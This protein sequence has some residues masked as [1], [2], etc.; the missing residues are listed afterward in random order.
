MVLNSIQSSNAGESQ[1]ILSGSDPKLSQTRK[2]A[3]HLHMKHKSL[4][5][6][7]HALGYYF[8]IKTH[9][10]LAAEDIIFRDTN[11]SFSKSFR[12]YFVSC[13]ITRQAS[14]ADG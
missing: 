13:S 11:G 7:G 6:L 9:G 8:Y 4:R 14:F 2:K 3:C 12:F 5:I 10:T 1:G